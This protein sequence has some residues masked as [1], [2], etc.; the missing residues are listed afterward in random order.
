MA[1]IIQIARAVLIR[2][3]RIAWTGRSVRAQSIVALSAPLVQIV[4][5]HA[6]IQRVARHIIGIQDKGFVLL[7]GNFAAIIRVAHAHFALPYRNFQRI[8][9]G[10]GY[11]ERAGAG[12]SDG[13]FLYCDV[14]FAIIVL[15][16]FKLGLALVKID[17]RK[18]CAG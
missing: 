9:I 3:L 2:R 6:F 18:R 11:A 1:V 17:C 12:K 5:V 15:R 8:G 10:A 16:D 7:Y 14:E 4:A 13:V